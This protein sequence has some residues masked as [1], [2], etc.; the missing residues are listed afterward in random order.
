MLALRYLTTKA[1][2][3]GFFSTLKETSAVNFPNFEKK[4]KEKRKGHTRITSCCVSSGVALQF[5]L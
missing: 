2:R 5:L 3:K 1:P 4:K